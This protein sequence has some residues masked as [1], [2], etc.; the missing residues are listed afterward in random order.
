MPRPKTN[1]KYTRF[2]LR[3]PEEAAKKIKS[4]AK[5]KPHLSLNAFCIEALM[6][7]IATEKQ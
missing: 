4:A 3:L 5:K 1:I 6:H 7:E 2:E